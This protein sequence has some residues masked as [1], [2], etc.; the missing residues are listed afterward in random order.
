MKS[1]EDFLF[2][3]Y[4]N[5][6]KSKEYNGKYK[7]N[8]SPNTKIIDENTKKIL[9]KELYKLR[10]SANSNKDVL[11]AI[12]ENEHIRNIYKYF[13]NYLRC[14]INEI[15][16]TAEITIIS[17]FYLKLQLDD[18]WRKKLG[19]YKHLDYLLDMSELYSNDM[20]K[21]YKQKSANAV[22]QKIQRIKY[23]LENLG[24]FEYLGIKRN[25]RQWIKII[26]DFYYKEYFKP[27]DINDEIIGCY[28]DDKSNK[29]HLTRYDMEL[30]INERYEIHK[31]SNNIY[32]DL[33]K[34]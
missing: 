24:I 14:F 15:I 16:M 29:R 31:I 4:Y 7:D 20:A 34:K 3:E 22:R 9:I 11:G 17:D 2:N 18:I 6:L 13:E 27:A 25:D 23:D 28:N 12:C 5:I 32:N 10:N 21:L 30:E 8:I 19:Q 1:K 26:S 33:F